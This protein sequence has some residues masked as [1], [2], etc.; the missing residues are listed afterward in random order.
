MNNFIALFRNYF[1]KN[2]KIIYLRY[3]LEDKIL[4]ILFWGNY[5]EHNN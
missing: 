2:L 5:E 1:E 4:K 3:K